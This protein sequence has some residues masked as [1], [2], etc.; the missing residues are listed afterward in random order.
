MAYR[1]VGEFGD[2][3]RECYVQA[4]RRQTPSAHV[5]DRYA[6][7]LA[8]DTGLQMM[9]DNLIGA[10]AGRDGHSITH[11]GHEGPRRSGTSTHLP[12]HLDF[13]YPTHVS[14]HRAAV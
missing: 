6:R 3:P 7:V 5:L 2:R 4:G 10:G 13:L 14:K 8:I 11:S 1:L 12:I 9:P